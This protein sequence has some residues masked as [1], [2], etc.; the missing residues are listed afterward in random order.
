MHVGS[1]LEGEA[2]VNRSLQNY[3]CDFLRGPTQRR[4]SWL[5]SLCRGFIHNNYL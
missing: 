3:G 5:D 1:I 2:R 4:K